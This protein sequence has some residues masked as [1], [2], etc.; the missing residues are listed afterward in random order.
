MLKPAS[1]TI[2]QNIVV[3]KALETLSLRLMKIVRPKLQQKRARFHKLNTKQHVVIHFKELGSH[4]DLVA[5]NK[6]LERHFITL[7]LIYT[8]FIEEKFVDL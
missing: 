3:N 6:K 4:A 2:T 8:N 7:D 1:D 5:H